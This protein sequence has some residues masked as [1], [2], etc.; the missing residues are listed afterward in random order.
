MRGGPLTEPLPQRPEGLILAGK[1][2]SLLTRRRFGAKPTDWERFN[3]PNNDSEIGNLN[4]DENPFNDPFKYHPFKGMAF[5]PTDYIGPDDARE[6]DSM[7]SLPGANALRLRFVYGYTSRKGCRNNLF[8]NKDGRIVYHNAALGIVYDKT[9]H[10]QWHFHGHDDD[11]TALD[12]SPKDRL[13]IVTG[14]MGKD[15]KIIVWNS[16]PDKGRTLQQLCLIHGDHKRSILG[17]AFNKTGE[18]IGTRTR[19][20]TLSIAPFPFPLSRSHDCAPPR[21]NAQRQWAS[22]TT[23]PS[24][25]TNG[26]RTGRSRRC[27]SAWTRATPTTS[28]SSCTT[29]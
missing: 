8:Y 1:G 23:V 26:A 11:I 29:R 21:Y 2:P 24:R 7:L 28:I 4:E 3:S 20:R 12:M 16:R 25:F 22:T 15:P 27:A 18:F 13:T 14:Q 6:T 10:E 9:N 17:L 19:A 5:P